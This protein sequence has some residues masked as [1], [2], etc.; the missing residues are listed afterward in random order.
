M[1]A[2][3]VEINSS[4]PEELRG[5]GILLTDAQARLLRPPRSTLFIPLLE[6]L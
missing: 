3:S 2:N 1:A 4:Y 6:P 5:G